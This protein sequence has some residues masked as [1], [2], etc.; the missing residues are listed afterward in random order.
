MKKLS[1]WKNCLSRDYKCLCLY[2]CACVSKIISQ[3]SFLNDAFL[4]SLIEFP[5]NPVIYWCNLPALNK[6]LLYELLN[7]NYWLIY[8][9]DIHSNK[10]HK[11]AKITEIFVLLLVCRRV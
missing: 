3:K 6:K 1:A 9:L 5:I 8:V 4:Y 10:S 2:V 11:P 7:R